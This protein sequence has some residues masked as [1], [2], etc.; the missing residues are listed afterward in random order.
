[1]SRISPSPNG[2]LAMRDRVSF[3]LPFVIFC[4][5]SKDL[6]TPNDIDAIGEYWHNDASSSEW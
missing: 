2:I 6:V 4:R 1:M 3:L 5:I